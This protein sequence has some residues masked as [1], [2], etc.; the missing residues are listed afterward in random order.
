VET[1]VVYA[2]S[3]LADRHLHFGAALSTLR[4]R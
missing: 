1:F 4:T 3:D 2:E